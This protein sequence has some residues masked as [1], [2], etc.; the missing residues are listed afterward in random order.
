MRSSKCSPHTDEIGSQGP[1]LHG[2]GPCRPLLQ[3]QQLS[4]TMQIEERGLRNNNS[5]P[6]DLTGPDPSAPLQFRLVMDTTTSSTSKPSSLD[7]ASTSADYVMHKA[8][9][10]KFSD[11]SKSEMPV[12]SRP[13]MR[14]IPLAANQFGR[15]GWHFQALLV[16]LAWNKVLNPSGCWLLRGPFAMT[17]EGA[18]G[19]IVRSW[20]ARLTWVIERA[21]AMNIVSSFTE[22]GVFPNVV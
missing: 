7:D 10:K 14:F 5:R 19:F 4:N 18:V 15:R 20:G 6:G 22:M 16:E 17:K 8:E 11:D 1:R 21:H 3:Y 13:G 9:S 2:P 12:Q